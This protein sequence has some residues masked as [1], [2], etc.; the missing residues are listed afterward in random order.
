MSS[1]PL[2][3]PYEAEAE[4]CLKL[5][6]ELLPLLPETATLPNE[7]DATFA[8]IRALLDLAKAAPSAV[9]GRARAAAALMLACL[10][11]TAANW[12][13]RADTLAGSGR[14]T[15]GHE[16]ARLIEDA[17]G[18]GDSNRHQRLAAVRAEA[19]LV[20]AGREEDA[21][22]VRRRFVDL[23]R[24]AWSFVENPHQRDGVGDFV[25]D[26]GLLE[27]R[28]ADGAVL[29]GLT[30]TELLIGQAVIALAAGEPAHVFEVSQATKYELIQWLI[31]S[32]RAPLE[33][34]AE[35]SKLPV[36]AS[37]R[38]RAYLASAS[39]RLA[40]SGPGPATS[41]G[42]EYEVGSV[43]VGLAV[44]LTWR[45]GFRLGA[46]ELVLRVGANTDARRAT[47]SLL[48][49]SAILGLEE[50]LR[51]LL[52]EDV[53]RAAGAASVTREAGIAALEA[54]RGAGSS[55][56]RLKLLDSALLDFARDVK[57]SAAALK[58]EGSTT[59][60]GSQANTRSAFTVRPSR[61]QPNDGATHSSSSA[62]SPQRSELGR[63]L[64][65]ATDAL[66][67]IESEAERE[68]TAFL[69]TLDPSEV[70]GEIRRQ[71]LLDWLETSVP[72][73]RL[74]E[75]SATYLAKAA[76]AE[77]QRQF[78]IATDSTCLTRVTEEQSLA[79][80]A[81]ASSL[82]GRDRPS[83]ATVAA[84]GLAHHARFM[85][86]SRAVRQDSLLDAL[87]PSEEDYE[88]L[89]SAKRL[90]AAEHAFVEQARDAAFEGA[91]I[92]CIVKA[93]EVARTAAPGAPRVL[94][95]LG[96]AALE[97]AVAGPPVNEH[98]S[99]T[100]AAARESFESVG[101][102]DALVWLAE[103]LAGSR[104]DPEDLA[105]LEAIV[106]RVGLGLARAK[107]GMSDPDGRLTTGPMPRRRKTST[108]RPA[109]SAGDPVAFYGPAT[110]MPDVPPIDKLLLALALD[111]E[112]LANEARLVPGIDPDLAARRF[113]LISGLKALR[114]LSATFLNSILP[115]TILEA[116]FVP[117]AEDARTDLARSILSW[118]SAPPAGI[119]R[120]EALVLLV[121][122]FALINYHEP[123]TALLREFLTEP[124]ARK[125]L[126]RE[127]QHALFSRLLGGQWTT[128]DLVALENLVG[129]T[130][131][132]RT[133]GPPHAQAHLQQEPG[134]MSSEITVFVAYTWE[135]EEH[136]ARVRGLAASLRGHGLKCDI[137]VWDNTT[138][139]G[140]PRWMQQKIATANFVL[141]VCTETYCRRFEGREEP[142]KGLGAN[143]EGKLI[144]A[145]ILKLGANN[146]KFIPV[147]F[148]T[149]DVEHIPA[150]LSDARYY[151][152]NENSGYE[153]LY[154]RLTN[155]PE[156]APPPVGK[157]RPLK[158]RV[159]EATFT[160]PGT[161]TPAKHPTTHEEPLEGGTPG[162]EELTEIPVGVHKA[163]VERYKKGDV[164]E[165]NIA[166]DTPLS[167]A[168]VTS[169]R[170]SDWQAGRCE[171]F[172]LDVK[173]QVP[174]AN[175]GVKRANL[176][177]EIPKD[178]RY[179][180]LLIN[181][182]RKRARDVR[183]SYR[184]T[185]KAKRT[186][187]TQ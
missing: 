142:G 107:S 73:P 16:L 87:A 88:A 110:Y 15:I 143:F 148:D 151:T 156:H 96:V 74:I 126:G 77:V 184:V 67:R 122:L 18:A 104:S 128:P 51:P 124:D 21:K 55:E 175:V 8:R 22:D 81:L 113:N 167:I 130:P 53:H 27:M 71:H 56:T 182:E 165:A 59:L 20:A 79:L 37:P 86:V 179:A 41:A 133:A 101:E 66:E 98:R 166:S 93:H 178:G 65:A 171:I 62:G 108:R 48:T 149:N 115:R 145:A 97:L 139:Q 90:A 39:A 129:A 150:I 105:R 5:L 153:A 43:A 109:P 136:K 60:P 57:H 19:E 78:L 70:P 100:F 102:P 24:Y 172:A 7:R 13:F 181:E 49:V 141:C 44:G 170:H 112:S 161:T 157:I 6:S 25:E 1:G 2:T 12:Q 64:V 134:V 68:A 85:G 52:R 26:A 47:L 176:R 132:E 127:V 34:I 83:F 11:R 72:G 144:N 180:F 123:G 106:G 164:F 174:Y 121:R 137:D 140:F 186:R 119:K 187:K 125:L 92:A 28:R 135:A 117:Q 173:S 84:H 17:H 94:A 158:T 38:L 131:D 54:V 4:R 30:P 29:P 50:D 152:L 111:A 33:R 58:D 10:G 42:D 163:H 183:W 159:E 9:R 154:R 155:Q 63:Q 169:R 35:L 185:K 23:Q 162:T 46:A 103:R 14:E 69:A 40:F 138:A 89:E 116:K 99:Q 160:L 31:P 114:R 61:S 75:L 177:V 147:V 3:T 76:P 45:T 168:F 91:F 80:R 95:T 146:E 82:L 118:I 120:S 32:A 36:P